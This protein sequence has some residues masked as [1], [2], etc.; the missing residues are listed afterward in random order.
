MGPGD[1]GVRI[2]HDLQRKCNELNRKIDSLIR[3]MEMMATYMRYS[4]MMAEVAA[5][6]AAASDMSSAAA[7]QAETPDGNDVDAPEGEQGMEQRDFQKIMDMAKRSDHPMSEGEFQEI[8][9]TL[10]QGKS[11]EEVARMEQMV[12]LARSFMK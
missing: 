10:K 7:F 5:A 12:K 2:L 9:N 11:E 4:G 1:N 6:Q 3:M 8:F